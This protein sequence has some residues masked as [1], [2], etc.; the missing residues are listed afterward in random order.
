VKM[1]TVYILRYAICIHGLYVCSI[2][3]NPEIPCTGVHIFTF[4]P[5]SC[6]INLASAPISFNFDVSAYIR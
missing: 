6:P 4:A 1:C 5:K 2:A 3:E